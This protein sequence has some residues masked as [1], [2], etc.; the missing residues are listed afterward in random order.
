MIKNTN[1]IDIFKASPFEVLIV[2]TDS[3]S[4]TVLGATNNFLTAYHKKEAD[5]LKKGFFEIFENAYIED[6]NN[7]IT[8][9]LNLFITCIQNKANAK[10][11]SIYVK[12]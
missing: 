2:L 4:F 3:P 6:S 11:K 10:F 5:I 12:P 1:N 8:D 7:K 9:L